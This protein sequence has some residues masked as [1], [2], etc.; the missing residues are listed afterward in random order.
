MERQGND[1][2]GDWQALA[3]QSW[4]A[5]S[6][7]ARQAG[8]ASGPAPGAATPSATWERVLDG[9]KGF[10]QWLQAAQAYGI[11]GGGSDWQRQLRSLF[12]HAGAPL[13]EA[14]GDLDSAGAHGFEALMKAW[15][16]AQ[17]LPALRELLSVP[18]FGMNRE[19]QHLQQELLAAVLD[20]GDKLQAYQAL[21]AKANADG[22]DRLEG[23]LA[24]MAEG[25]ERVETLKALYNLWVEAAEAAY[26]EV[27]MSQAFRAAYGELTDAQMRMRALQHRQV[28]QLS[29]ELGMP[30]RSEVDSLGKRLQEL[31][32][33]VRA[34]GHGEGTELETLRREVAELRRRVA[35]FEAAGETAPSA[36]PAAIKAGTGRR[37]RAAS[38]G[39]ASKVTKTAKTGKSTQTTAKRATGTAAKQAAARKSGAGKR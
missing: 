7:F 24:E 27:A 9:M 28:A 3:R 32:R 22:V 13:A 30:T 31:R 19:H 21:L 29:R 6:Q 15:S 8:M 18:G 16:G 25:G 34:A 12:E 38:G 17:P 4:D 11:D 26:A 5:W 36:A 39:R 37:S 14:V 33:Q 10:N 1:L 20:Y 23:K 35:A 2:L